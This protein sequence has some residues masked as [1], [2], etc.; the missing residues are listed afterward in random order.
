MRRQVGGLFW[1]LGLVFLVGIGIGRVGLPLLEPHTV[2]DIE[3]PNSK[4][5]H[6]CVLDMGDEKTILGR[7]TE[8]G[9]GVHG[10]GCGKRWDFGDMSIRCKCID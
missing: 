5:W 4:D 8:I 1:W 6:Q 10:F 9:E 7:V 3:I 2:H